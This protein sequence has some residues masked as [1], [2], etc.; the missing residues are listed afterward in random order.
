M[1]AKVLTLK[2]T[3]PSYIT[4][5]VIFENDH[6]D[7]RWKDGIQI[8]CAQYTVNNGDTGNPAVVDKNGNTIYFQ[9]IISATAYL[10]ST[11]VALAC[12]VTTDATLGDYVT[13]TAPTAEVDYTVN[14]TGIW[15]K[16]YI[17]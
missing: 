5:G 2:T 14:I 9:K 8:L 13:L 16:R 1:A 17:K 3:T 11:G 6:S 10:V 4:D 12:V 7:V 15:K